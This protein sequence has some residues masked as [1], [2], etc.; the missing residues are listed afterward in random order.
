MEKGYQESYLE[1][2][3]AIKLTKRENLSSG[4]KAKDVR[5]HDP[6]SE[7]VEPAFEPHPASWVA[8]IVVL[9]P[10]TR[11]RPGCDVARSRKK[12][13][14]S[15]ALLLD[16]R[17]VPERAKPFNPIYLALVPRHLGMHLTRTRCS[18]HPPQPHARVIM[19]VRRRDN[20]LKVVNPNRT[21]R[22]D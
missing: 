16:E 15:Q 7:I 4:M 10:R 13:E 20:I 5:R 9:E 22:A 11:N 12:S 2:Y 19:A 17:A 1:L 21:T 8:V 6:G 3:I 18:K 14:D